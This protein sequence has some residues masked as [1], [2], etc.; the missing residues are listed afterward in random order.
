MTE[1]EENRRICHRLL[2]WT[3]VPDRSDAW[4]TPAGDRILGTPA[5]IS[6]GSIG[7]AWVALHQAGW[8]RFDFSIHPK[9]VELCV[10]NLLGEGLPVVDAPDVPRALRAAALEH[11]KALP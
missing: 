5:F 7:L 2:N 11:I 10:G 4:R 3:P 8:V 1:Q 9:G 6:F